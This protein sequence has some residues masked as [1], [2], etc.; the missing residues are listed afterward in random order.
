MRAIQTTASTAA[1]AAT[2]Q[3]ATTARTLSFASAAS[4]A[5]KNLVAGDSSDLPS[6]ARR[7]TTSRTE[8]EDDDKKSCDQIVNCFS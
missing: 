1:V 7:V 5:T 8:A 3:T 6:K 4:D 2:T